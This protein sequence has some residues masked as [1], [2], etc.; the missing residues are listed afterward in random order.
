MRDSGA[1]VV[2]FAV[3]ATMM[4]IAPSLA[5]LL[6]GGLVGALLAR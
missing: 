6:A 4:S 2:G 5:A 1:L 3:G